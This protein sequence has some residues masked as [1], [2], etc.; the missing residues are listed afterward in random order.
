MGELY[1]GKLWKRVI[2]SILDYAL[3]FALAITFYM[4][5]SNGIIDIGFHNAALKESQ[6][7]LQEDS[8]LFNV[9]KDEKGKITQVKLLEFDSE[10]IDSYKTFLTAINDYYFDF[11]NTENQNNRNLNIEYFGFNETTLE[12]EI[13]KINSIDSSID[14]FTL[15][16]VVID[17]ETNEECSLSKNKE[18]YINAISNYFLSE[19][20]GVYNYALTTFTSLDEFKNIDLNIAY[21][22]RLEI[23]ICVLVSS[24]VTFAIPFLINK[25]GESMFMHFLKLGYT[26]RNGYRVSYPLKI[27]RLIVILTLNTISMYLYLIPFIV[28]MLVLFIHKEKR[29]LVDIASGMVCVDLNRS[30][31]YKDYEEME[32]DNK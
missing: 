27:I 29:S 5:L 7:Q 31:I 17:V 22:E 32:K 11:L 10:N 14:E 9:T 15:K 21:V 16:E 24:I 3:M 26:N 23:M 25:N 8:H 6:Y 2:A 1:L 28:N 20:N 13:F 12:N 4:F 18:D 19:E 30:T